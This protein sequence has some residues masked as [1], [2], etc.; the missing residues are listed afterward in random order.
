[1]TVKFGTVGFYEAMADQLNRD[2]EWTTLGKAISYSMI[3]DYG[4]PV[5]KRFFAL[6]DEGRVIE[7]REAA[8]DESDVD[9]AISGPA[10]LWRGIFDQTVN[11]TA[12]L[13]KGQMKVKGK[14]TALLKNMNAFNYVIDSMT[15][16]DF[17]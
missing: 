2:P 13:M 15:K 7:V 3:F 8:P 6:F 17:E 10:D 14:M 5:D 1:M 16:I 11:P 4:P 9:F 12:A